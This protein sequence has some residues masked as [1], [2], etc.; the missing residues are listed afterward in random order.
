MVRSGC[1]CLTIHSTMGP[2]TICLFVCLTM[3]LLFAALITAYNLLSETSS[4][5]SCDPGSASPTPASPAQLTACLSFPQRWGKQKGPWIWSQTDLSGSSS[6]TPTFCAISEGSLRRG[7]R[8]PEKLV[9]PAIRLAPPATGSEEKAVLAP[10]TEEMAHKPGAPASA[11]AAHR[12]GS[13]CVSGHLT[14][15]PGGIWDHGDAGTAASCHSGHQ[16]HL[17]RPPVRPRHHLLTLDCPRAP[18]K[19]RN[20]PRSQAVALLEAGSC[21]LEGS[22]GKSSNVL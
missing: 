13:G 2:Q 22:L 4:L 5:L 7:S 14:L 17:Q 20:P 19:P 11:S 21:F 12:P 3:K 6:S 8:C 1:A 10:C 18:S 15:T 16:L 9:V